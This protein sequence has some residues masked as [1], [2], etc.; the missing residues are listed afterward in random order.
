MNQSGS[1]RSQAAAA[2]RRADLTALLLEV[3]D[4]KLG[5]VD[6][7]TIAILLALRARSRPP[8]SRSK[9][10]STSDNAQPPL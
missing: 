6:K 5:R 4:S 10:Y 9:E 3:E 2:I 7:A 1:D 8:R